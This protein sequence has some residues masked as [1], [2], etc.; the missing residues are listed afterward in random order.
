MT[1]I[2]FLGLGV[3]EIYDP[4]SI[5]NYCRPWLYYIKDIYG[6]NAYIAI[7]REFYQSS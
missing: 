4:Q 5:M 1:A 7:K 3:Y 6:Q 2:F